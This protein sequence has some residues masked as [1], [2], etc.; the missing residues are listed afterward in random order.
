MSISKHFV[1]DTNPLDPRYVISTKSGRR[2]VIGEID[3]NKPLGRR[4]RP[5]K[6]TRRYLRT[7]DIEGA[8]PY[9]RRSGIKHSRAESHNNHSMV[10]STINS[11]DLPGAVKNDIINRA[12]VIVNK[13]IEKLKFSYLY[14]LLKESKLF[15]IKT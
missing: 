10:Y 13:G 2:Q 7:D 5:L 14:I 15:A 9:Y 4:K 6:D 3:R 1:K 12:N 8:Q 11:N